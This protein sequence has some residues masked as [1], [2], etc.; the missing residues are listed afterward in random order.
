MELTVLS[1]GGTVLLPFPGSLR[2]PAPELSVRDR[3]EVEGLRGC[4]LRAL[5]PG[6]LLNL[7]G[8]QSF[9]SNTG[10]KSP[11]LS[12]LSCGSVE[13]AQGPLYRIT[14]RMAGAP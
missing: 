14:R 9:A 8:P 5:R 6:K 3:S 7:R 12:L 2:A 1:S 10:S 13:G 11:C 4:L